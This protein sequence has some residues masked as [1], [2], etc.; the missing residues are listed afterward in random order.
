MV[1][2]ERS[3]GKSV[4]AT[5]IHNQ[6]HWGGHVVRMDDDRLPKEL[7]YGEMKVGK[8]P[9]HKPKKRYKDCVKNN[10]NVLHI[11]ANSS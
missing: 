6:M 9:Q 2:L 7:F 1:F 4:E 3:E 8:R 11:D 10:L 5:L